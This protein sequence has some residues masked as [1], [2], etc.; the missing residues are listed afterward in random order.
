M[1]LDATVKGASSN[2]YATVAQADAYFADRLGASAWN[3][4]GDEII[5][6]S[7]ATISGIYSSLDDKTEVTVAGITAPSPGLVLGDSMQI[8]TDV[9]GADGTHF[10]TKV[11]SSTSFQ[12]I[13]SGN[14]SAVSSITYL[15]RSTYSDKAKALIM[16]TRYLDQLMYLG[17]RTL[18]TQKLSFPRMFL[19]DPDATAVFW[20]QALR[21]RSD[22]FDDDIIPDRVL[23]AT[24]ELALKLLG[25]PELTGDP[26]VRQFRKVNIDGV[27]SVEFNENALPRALD[28]NILNYINP[29]L[30]AGGGPSVSLRR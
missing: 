30:Q 15:D 10:I 24:Y 25:D 27:L 2:S 1:A 12:F 20:G 3:S 23:F 14:H 4:I 17:E 8:V 11:V 5:G 13:V 9:A 16:A 21:L 19:P 28:R 26:T 18:T 6:I 7:S 22:Y 29:L